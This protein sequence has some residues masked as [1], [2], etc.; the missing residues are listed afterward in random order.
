MFGLPEISGH[1]R[2]Q[3]GAQEMPCQLTLRTSDR[4][5]LPP[6][7]SRIA[8][9]VSTSFPS[10]N[11]LRS[12]AEFGESHESI[13]LLCQQRKFKSRHWNVPREQGSFRPWNWSRQPGISIPSRKRGWGKR[14][15]RR[16]QFQ[17][18]VR[19]RSLC[20]RGSLGQWQNSSRVKGTSHRRL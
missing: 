2:Y 11:L 3:L 14:Q 9:Y 20:P 18:A 7:S 4:T 1:S 10:I 13:W 19:K 8:L 17:E 12:K 5:Y 15:T 6:R 16:L